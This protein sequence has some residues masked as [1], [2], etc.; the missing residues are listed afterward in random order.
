MNNN[1]RLY[2]AIGAADDALVECCEHKRTWKQP[3]WIRFGA[4]A[5]CLCLILTGAF[6]LR[7]LRTPMEQDLLGANGGIVCS[8]EAGQ[9]GSLYAPPDNGKVLL[10]PEVSAALD[11]NAG[12]TYF[13]AVDI[14]RDRTLLELESSEVQGEIKRLSDNGYRVG[15]AT[16]WAYQGE[17]MEQIDSP[18]LA[19]Y[20]TAEQLKEFA[21]D[22][23]FGYAFSFAA[24]G[25]GSNVAPD[26]ELAAELPN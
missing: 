23:S 6:A 5:A 1:E 3:V 25:D 24:N 10:F 17:D 16:C 11:A 2:T 20:F 8:Y 15:L 12:S 18:Y 13:V 7:G 21:A 9:S 4:V 22:S 14:Y 26:Q 19:G